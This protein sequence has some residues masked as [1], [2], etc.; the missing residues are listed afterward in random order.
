MQLQRARIDPTYGA[1]LDEGLCRGGLASR[2]MGAHAGYHACFRRASGLQRTARSGS[3]IPG[4]HHDQLF[5]HSIAGRL[6]SVASDAAVRKSHRALA[7]R[8]LCADSRG[9]RVADH[10]RLCCPRNQARDSG[11]SGAHAPRVGCCHFRVVCR[12]SA[13]GAELCRGVHGPVRS[14]H[15]LLDIRAVDHARAAVSRRDHPRTAQHQGPGTGT[16]MRHILIAAGAFACALTASFTALAADDLRFEVLV[17]PEFERHATLFAYPGY[18]AIA[19]ESIG[20]SPSLSSKLRVGNA[21]RLV[22]IRFGML[23]F[24]GSKDAVYSYEASLTSGLGEGGPRLTFPVTVDASSLAAGK[25][26]ITARPPLA[27]LIPAE[28]NDRIELKLRTI[29]N[30]GAQK[31]ILGYLDQLAKT[32]KTDSSGLREA[33]LLDS[34]NRSGGGSAGGGVDVGEALPLSEQW[35]LIL[36]LLIWVVAVPAAYFYSLRRQRGKPA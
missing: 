23:R 31:Q 4:G 19:L 26:I 29:A 10:R 35:M 30:A 6:R 5:R 13:C 21:G 25:M 11:P 8:A 12:V 36:T 33:I 7:R 15:R 16:E 18:A 14:A 34:Y 3:D 22:E 17:L 20:L 1:S 24:A 27:S 28:V 2:E 9:R 32:A